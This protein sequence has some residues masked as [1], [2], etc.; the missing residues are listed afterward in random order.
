MCSSCP[1]NWSHRTPL[2]S[3]DRQPQRSELRELCQPLALPCKADLPLS[4][5]CA[6]RARPP[7]MSSWQIISVGSGSLWSG[8]ELSFWL[9]LCS[10]LMAIFDLWQVHPLAFGGA[11]RACC[12]LL[13]AVH[14][15]L[16]CSVASTS[17]Q[18]THN[19]AYFSSSPWLPCLLG[20]GP[21]QTPPQSSTFQMSC[22]SSPPHP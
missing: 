2:S 8:G 19:L 15:I 18:H 22:S 1:I 3:R 4:P 11:G 20:W 17:P 5:G 6:P 7:G 21:G 12:L 13:F 9:D 16:A 10:C 14:S